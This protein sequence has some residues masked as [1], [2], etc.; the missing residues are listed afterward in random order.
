VETTREQVLRYVRGHRDAT[1]AQLAAALELSQQAVRRHLDGLRA[2]GLIDASFERH[3]VG[4]P[5]LV[6]FA[7]ERG[8]ET[9]GRTYLQLL[10]RLVRHLDRGGDKS[11]DGSILDQVFAGVAQEIAAEHAAEVRGKTLDERV[12]ET[13]RAL[14]PEGI[15]DGWRKEGEVFHIYNNDCPYLRLAEINGVACRSDQQSIELLTGVQVEQIRRIVDGEPV[16]EYIIRPASDK[17]KA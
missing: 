17:A 8:E 6:F 1:V 3:G 12:A 5:A 14:E 4:R 16:C 9:S 2:A 13:S 11:R 10:S 15:V 7:T